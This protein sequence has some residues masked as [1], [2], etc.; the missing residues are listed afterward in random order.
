MG[1]NKFAFIPPP[2]PGRKNMQDLWPHLNFSVFV[3]EKPALTNHVLEVCYYDIATPLNR[4][5][6]LFDKDRF[7]FTNK[8]SFYS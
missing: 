4:E 2:L 7:I 1:D 5:T 6:D 8:Q 3:I